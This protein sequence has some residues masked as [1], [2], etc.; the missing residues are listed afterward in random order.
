MRL[1]YLISTGKGKPTPA[2]VSEAI[3][4]AASWRQL[5]DHV[6]NNQLG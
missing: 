1:H 6:A 2:R 4:S 3:E 5:V